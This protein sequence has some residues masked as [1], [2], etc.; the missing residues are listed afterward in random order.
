MSLAHKIIK[1]LMITTLVGTGVAY[2]WLYLK[3]THVQNYLEQ[4]A[5]VQQ[6]REISDFITVGESGEVAL[7]LPP[8]LSE[9]Y[10]SVKSSYRYAVRDAAGRI[11]AA[12]GRGVGPL[13]LLLGSQRRFYEQNSGDTHIVGAAIE[14]TI[15]QQTFTTQVEQIAPRLQSINAAVFNEFIADGGWLIFVF[16]LAQLGISVFTVRRGLVPLAK[17]SALAGSISPGSSSIRLPQSG[18]PQEI[19]PLVGAVNSALDRLDEGMQQQREFTANAA[20]QL[21]TPLTVLAANIDMMSDEAV[22]AKLRYDV[23]LMS[24]IVTQLLLVARLENLNIC[25][26]EQVELSSMVREAAE[27]LGPLAISTHKTLE[28]DGPTNPVFVRGNT[29]AV[30]A[31]VSNLIENALNHS[32]TGGAVRIRV[33]STPSI[34]VLDSGP[35]VPQHMR[36]KIFER[37]WRGESSKEGAGLGLAI[38]RRIMRALRGDVSVADAPGGGAKFSLDFPVFSTDVHSTP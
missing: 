34:E 32:P 6:A 30:V 23:D 20:H 29:R 37:F 27:N 31:A 1:R 8:R 22:A 36:E 16:L 9:A 7:N 26:D 17:L 33:T 12:S 10:N 13:P 15:E 2:G 14:T 25:V 24:R 3:A 4:R 38:V 21:R 19:L 18:V 35:G 11:V 5:L 28:V